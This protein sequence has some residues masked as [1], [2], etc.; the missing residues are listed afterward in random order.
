L[1][2]PLTT[3]YCFFPSMIHMLAFFTT[4]IDRISPE[5]PTL[6]NALQGSSS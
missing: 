1:V 4:L 5:T 6:P 3:I 2:F